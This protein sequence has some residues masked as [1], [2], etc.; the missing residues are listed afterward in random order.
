MTVASAARGDRHLDTELKRAVLAYLGS[1]HPL[2]AIVGHLWGDEPLNAQ[3]RR[4]LQ[5]DIAAHPRWSEREVRDYVAEQ[6][7]AEAK[8][9]GILPC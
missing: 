4:L 5:P 7:L 6:L 2:A 3:Q 9:R 1:S 8:A